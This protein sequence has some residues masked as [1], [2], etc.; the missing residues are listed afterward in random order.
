MELT[1]TDI[2]QI[3]SLFN[4]YH[5]NELRLEIGDSKLYI[6]RNAPGTEASPNPAH[7]QLSDVAELHQSKRTKPET[8]EID[9]HT[10]ATTQIND[11]PKSEETK[12]LAIKAPMLGTCY[13]APDPSQPPYVQIGDIVKPE[14]TIC[15]LEVMKL[16]SPVK[17]GVTGRLKQFLV[18]D[19]D[20]VEYG[21][22]I[23]LIDTEGADS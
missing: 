7:A 3:L 21:Q 11:E 2:K 19:G 18:S 17:A 8:N 12:Y 15:L 14:D 1:K 20:T 16:F 4:D 6:S 9:E 10:T 22:T 13:R 23:A 5:Y